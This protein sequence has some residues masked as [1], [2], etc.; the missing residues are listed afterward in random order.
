MIR[1]ASEVVLLLVYRCE[2]TWCYI[3]VTCLKNCY[4]IYFVGMESEGP[5]HTTGQAQD[6]HEQKIK[7]KQC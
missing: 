1:K 7:K 2:L 3:L 4:N 5:S 6:E